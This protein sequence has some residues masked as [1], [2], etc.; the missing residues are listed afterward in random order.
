M[1]ASPG[2]FPFTAL[3]SHAP[4]WHK[5]ISGYLVP[6]SWLQIPFLGSPTVVGS[7]KISCARAQWVLVKQMG[8]QG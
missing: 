3:T 6:K 4:A 7:G 1:F 5:A 8:D 2:N